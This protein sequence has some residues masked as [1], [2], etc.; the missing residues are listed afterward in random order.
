MNELF[1]KTV[2]PHRCPCCYKW[3]RHIYKKA[4]SVKSNRHGN[5]AIWRC[6]CACGFK[7]SSEP[8]PNVK[9]MIDSSQIGFHLTNVDKKWKIFKSMMKRRKRCL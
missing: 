4:L 7:V 3:T 5:F 6:C 9:Y 1:M 8:H 2:F